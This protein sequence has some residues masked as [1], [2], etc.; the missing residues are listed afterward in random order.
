[1]VF[2]FGEGKIEI[3]LPKQNYSSGELITGKLLLTLNSPKKARE[4]RVALS[5]TQKQQVVRTVTDR[6]A[7]SGLDPMGPR[8]FGIN[9]QSSRNQGRYSMEYDIKDVVV[10]E[11]KAVLDGEKEYSG[12]SEYSFEIS[13]P[14]LNQGNVPQNGVINVLKAL[15]PFSQSPGPIRWELAASLDVPGSFD[16]N[17]KIQISI[18]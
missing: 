17:K 5:G 1:M 10:Y 8:D 11:F 14:A 18:V 16:V 12:F 9:S 6:R 7:G 3:Q 4:L 13:A 15:Q 2:G